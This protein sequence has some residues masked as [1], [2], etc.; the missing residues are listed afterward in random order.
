MYNKVCMGN[1]ISNHKRKYQSSE[2]NKLSLSGVS[3]TVV[4]EGNKRIEG[5]ASSK[6][7]MAFLTWLGI[8][9]TLLG[10]FA[11]MDAVKATI[12]YVA[13]LTMVVIRFSLWVY[14]V[15]QTNKLK[16]IELKERELDYISKQQAIKEKE[17]EQLERELNLRV[18]LLNP[19]NK[20]GNN[21]K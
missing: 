17:I 16:A 12:L 1:N 8:P 21:N 4:V 2:S 7:L 6:A 19:K 11:H 14:R 20:D 15:I 5:M 3:G 10:V 18:N 13:G 9:S